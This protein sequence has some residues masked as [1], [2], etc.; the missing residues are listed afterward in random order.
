MPRAKSILQREFPYHVTARCSNQEWFGLPLPETWD[1]I[2]DYL[3]GTATC[4]NLRIVSFVLMSNHFH[5]ILR[6]PDSNLDDAM[7]Y[8]LRETS[9]YLGGRLNRINQ[10]FGGPHSRSIITSELYFSH[11][12]KYVYRNPVTAGICGR[13]EEYPFSTLSGIVGQTRLAVPVFDD[14]FVFLRTEET[15]SWLNTAPSE[16]DHADVKKA[17]RRQTF[18][19]PRDKNNH[20]HRLSLDT[21]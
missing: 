1:I 16:Q 19:L 4:F 11:A 6:T 14:P 12:Y 17:L 5:M 7:E 20:P 21:L 15:L 9:K 13:V 18:T 2:T 10:I 3:C 8:F